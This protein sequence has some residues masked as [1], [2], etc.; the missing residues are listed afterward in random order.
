MVCEG[1]EERG[2]IEQYLLGR[3]SRADRDAFE[4]HAFE[5][6][7]CLT[8]LDTMR[9][10]QVELRQQRGAIPAETTTVRRAP[11]RWQGPLAAAAAIVLVAVGLGWELRRIHPAQSS[12]T[13]RT[14]PPMTVTAPLSGTGAGSAPPPAASS[15][16]ALALA[17]IEPPRYL[18]FTMR[19][20]EDDRARRFARAMQD[21]SNGDYQRAATGLR[22][23][24][25]DDPEDVE[26]NFFLG[27]ALLM[28]GDVDGGIER[29]R[30]AI[31]RGDSLF[32]QLASLDVA[33]ALVR[34]G[35]LAAA[36]RELNRTITFQGSHRSEA[37]DLLHRLQLLRRSSR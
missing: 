37:S 14:T 19:G 18:P 36:E 31:A 20:N 11:W 10:L 13:V 27:I 9:I 32:R 29:L 26:T 28:T 1:I 3:L 33:K 15:D 4:A 24:L 6:D 35:D 30:A 16:A 12:P 25:A 34:K 5:C 7:R 21:Y 2:L 17:R 22:R 8:A 23:V